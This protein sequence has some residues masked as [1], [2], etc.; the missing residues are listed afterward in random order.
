MGNRAFHCIGISGSRWRSNRVYNLLL[1]IG[2]GVLFCGCFA[3]L[4]SAAQSDQGGSAD[5]YQQANQSPDQQTP[6]QQSPDQQ[7]S[8]QQTAG[9]QP[10]GQQPA[11]QQSA[12]QQPGQST[13]QQ[14]MS[15][16]Q[17]IDILQQEPTVLTDVKNQV[18]QQS[19]TDPSTITDDEL[20]NRIRQDARLRAQITTALNKL[21]YSTNS[22]AP[23][24]PVLEDLALS[25]LH[26]RNRTSL[27]KYGNLVRMGIYLRCGIFTLRHHPP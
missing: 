14:A 23:A 13:E 27:K 3:A 4:K 11:G 22:I 26:T 5:P 17:I 10:A 9:Q 1:N 8:D 2:L 25:P 12:G 19:G 21:G 20:Y 7:S 18:A 15:A 6:D 24:P 16:E